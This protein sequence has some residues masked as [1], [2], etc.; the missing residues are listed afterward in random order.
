LQAFSISNHEGRIVF[1]IFSLSVIT[2]A[3]SF[4]AVRMQA[5][6]TWLIS[7]GLSVLNGLHEI[8]FLAI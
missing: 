7:I 4:C 8:L 1:V 6:K 5:S 2:P 3:H